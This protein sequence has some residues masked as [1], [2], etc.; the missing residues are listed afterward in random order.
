V[1]V[2]ETV[3][4]NTPAIRET[5]ISALSNVERKRINIAAELLSDP[6]LIYL[7]EATTDLDPGL[8][9]KMMYTFRQMADEGRTVVVTTRATN[10]IV[11]T[12]HV[13][14]LSEGKLVYFGPADESLSFFEVEEFADIYER[15]DGN[16]E[17]WRTVFEQKKPEHRKK[18]VEDR[19]KSLTAAP[20]TTLPKTHFSIKDCVHQFLVLTQRALRLLAS[21]RTALFWMLFLFPVTAILQLF[22]AQPDVLTGNLAILADPIAAAKTIVTSYVPIPATTVFIFLMA[23]EA[24]FAGLFL[25]LNDLVTERSIFLRERMVNL[26]ILPYL[27]SKLLLSSSFAILQVLLYLVLLSLGVKIPHLGLYFNGY[28]ELF[29]SLFLTVLV[30]ISLG[31]LVSAL[32]K[33]TEMTTSIL[34][35][36]LVVQFLF[37]GA[38]FDLRSKAVEPLS[39]LSPTRWSVTALGVTIDMNRIAQSTILC[40][41]VRENSSDPNSAVK[42]ECFHA[43]EAKNG[44]SLNYAN[45]QL[46]RSWMVLLGM[47]ILCWGIT[48]ILLARQGPSR[49]TA[50]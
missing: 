9:K 32:S 1:A 46:L 40:K 10:N 4:M 37:A 3:S 39:Y 48:W 11:Q 35:L 43:P 6:K 17:H 23:L 42:T 14:V 27:G 2:L 7:D 38:L 30:G 49:L 25:P 47:I 33:S 34:L 28:I 36:I 21:N 8:E 19:Q 26:R 29:I 12:D 24:V 44:L 22:I 16:G 18:Y 41:E 13:G 20:K 31:L 5:R 45:D 15:I 50:S